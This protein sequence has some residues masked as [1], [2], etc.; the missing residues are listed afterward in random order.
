MSWTRP[1]R[2]RPHP[3]ARNPHVQTVLGMALR[4]RS[5]Q[6]LFRERIDTPDGDF[7]EL[8]WLG[9]APARDDAP[10]VLMVHGL[11][12]GLQSGYLHTAAA[13]LGRAG[14]AS[15][16]LQL[17]GAGEEPSRRDHVYHH[18]DTADFRHAC[19]LLRRRFPRRKLAALGWSLGGN[20]VLKGLGEDRSRSPLAAAMA[21]SAPLRLVECTRHLQTEGRVYQTLMLRY[22][23]RL[24]RAHRPGGAVDLKAVMRAVDFAQFGDAYIAPLLGFASNDA[25]CR[26]VS[27]GAFLGK[28][29][30]PTLV[31]QSSDDPF[32]GAG[33]LPASRAAPAVRIEL[34]RAGGHVG[35]VSRGERGYPASWLEGRVT[36]FLRRALARA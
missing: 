25:Y 11:G 7:Y 18:G 23:K 35:F 19:R 9:E 36:R 17:R 8:G 26:A 10:L 22:A 24:V 27:S 33:A 4:S 31:L 13:A 12:G 20:V 3:W 2:F 16:A 5:P 1:S 14:I 30:R 15:V 6:R 21:I 34:A 32:L 29:R 28:I